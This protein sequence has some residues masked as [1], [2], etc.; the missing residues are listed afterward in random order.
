MPNPIGGVAPASAGTGVGSGAAPTLSAEMDRQ[1]ELLSVDYVD[2][3]DKA[4]VIGTNDPRYIAEQ[5]RSLLASMRTAAT[6][7][8]SDRRYDLKDCI[9]ELIRR[10]TIQHNLNMEMFNR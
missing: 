10:G 1:L 4:V 7:H 9:D 6:A 8:C 5:K 3:Y 2:H